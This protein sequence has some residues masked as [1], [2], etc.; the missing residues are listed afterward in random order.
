MP[1]GCKT[2]N[3]I[4]VRLLFHVISLSLKK[5]EENTELPCSEFATVLFSQYC[6]GTL[7][8]FI[9]TERLDSQTLDGNLHDFTHTFDQSDRNM[10]PDQV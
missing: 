2:C 4:K 6:P 1:I 3:F 9:A 5:K 7:I 10:T 8:V